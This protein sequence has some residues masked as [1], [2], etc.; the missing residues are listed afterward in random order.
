MWKIKGNWNEISMSNCNPVTHTLY[1][2]SVRVLLELMLKMVMSFLIWMLV[3][4]PASVWAVSSPNCKAVWPFQTFLM[5]CFLSYDMVMTGAFS[6]IEDIVICLFVCLL[7]VF[8]TPGRYCFLSI[9]LFVSLFS[10]HSGYSF[11]SSIFS[12]SSSSF[13]SFPL[14]QIHFSSTSR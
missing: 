12:I 5:L 14:F 3:I 13:P 6:L 9:Y 4:K 10:I 2:L 1:Y 11:P 7:V 8:N